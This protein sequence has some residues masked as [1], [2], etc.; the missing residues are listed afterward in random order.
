MKNTYR[1]PTVEKGKSNY[2]E[3]SV[4]NL[5]IWHTSKERE[6]EEEEKKLKLKSEDI[7]DC[8]VMEITL[9]KCR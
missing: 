7:K 5:S 3:K 2:V 8:N 9:A 1:R 6:R 4:L